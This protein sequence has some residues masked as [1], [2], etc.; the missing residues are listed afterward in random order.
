MEEP[1]FEHNKQEYPP[2]HSAEHILNRTMVNIYGCPRS[3]ENHIE[4]KKSKCHYM[5]DHDLTQDEV[6]EITRR[7]N[8]VINSHVDVRYEFVTE[9]QIPDN[10]SRATLPEGAD[11]FRLVYIGDY[12]VCLCV[13]AHV[14]NTSEIGECRITSHSYADGKL[15]FVFKLG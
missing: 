3:V 6:D 2:M 7:V 15:R 12:D 5:I 9:D 10:V 1:V 13:G 11:K 8:E 4:R 14:Q